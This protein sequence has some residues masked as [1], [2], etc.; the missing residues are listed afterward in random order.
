M[1][2]I[3]SKCGVEK[4]ETNE[5]FKKT[6]AN[7]SGVTGRCK[8]CDSAYQREWNKKNHEAYLAIRKRR[9]VNNKEKIDDYNKKW[10]KNNPEASARIKSKWLKNNPE[11]RADVCK[12]WQHNNRVSDIIKV[13]RRNAK[14]KHLLNN[15]TLDQWEGIKQSFNNACAYCGE[16]KKLTIEHFVPVN[17]LGELSANNVLPVC[18]FCNSSKGA[19]VFFTWYPTFKH[20]SKSREQKILRFLNYKNGIQQLSISI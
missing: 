13:Q 1:G 3:C 6:K 8:K 7:K 9:Y 12:K 11:K 20:Y 15:L 10:R 16:V 19:K 5:Y 4:P 18:Q 17:K 14:K 2:K